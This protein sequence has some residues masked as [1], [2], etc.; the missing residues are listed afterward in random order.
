MT[1]KDVANLLNGVLVGENISFESINIPSLAIEN[2]LS[3]LKNNESLSLL[4]KS[5]CK[6]FIISNRLFLPK[7]KNYIIVNTD[8]I[9]SV[10]KLLLE[11]DVEEK[12][13][14]I[15][16]E[17]TIS[18]ASHVGKR[19][20]IGKETI[21]ED[22][23][24]I[25]DNVIIGN[26]VIIHS[27][28]IIGKPGF[29]HYKFEDEIIT[30]KGIGGVIIEDNVEI[31]CNSCVDAGIFNDTKIGRDTKIDNFC[32]IGHDVEIGEK[33]IICS[34]VGIAGYTKIGKNSLLY[35]KVGVSDSL[36]LGD[37]FIAKGYSA[38]TK[39]FQ[40]KTIVSGIPARENIKNLK[41]LSK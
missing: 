33:T 34:Q 24:K 16:K 12:E 40:S 32:Q 19:V 8:P 21:I 10:S 36:I 18:K 37:E 22:N 15:E 31:G 27:G 5:K 11:M 4:K 6:N 13:H 30:L 23:V 20:S 38:V 2:N 1:L 7:D 9:I 25:Y 3:F 28:S 26:N 14:K 29:S 35:G 41:K 17:S 39:S